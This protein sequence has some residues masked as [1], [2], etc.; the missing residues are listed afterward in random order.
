LFSTPNLPEALVIINVRYDTIRY[1]TEYYIKRMD[2]FNAEPIARAKIMFLGN[3]ITEFGDWQKLLNDPTV[4]N[5][6]I[7]ADNTFGVIDRLE[8]VISRHP[9]K[10]FYR[11]R[12]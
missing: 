6:G 2:V 9:K 4:V 7:A 12:H 11:N 3:S 5:R 8:D 1:A 10:L